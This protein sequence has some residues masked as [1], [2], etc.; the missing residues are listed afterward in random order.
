MSTRRRPSRPPRRASARPAAAA[1]ASPT[2]IAS[3]RS[4]PAFTCSTTALRFWNEAWTWPPRRSVITG[5]AALVGTCRPWRPRLA[6]RRA[7]RSD[8]HD[9]PLPD[10]A[11][12]I[13]SGF[14]LSAA[15]TSASALER[16]SSG[17]HQHVGRLHGHRDQVE[18]LER[19][20][21]HVLDQVRCDHQRPERGDE[22]RVTVGSGALDDGCA[23]RAGRARLVLDDERLPELLLQL[24]R[25]RTGDR[26]RGAARGGTARRS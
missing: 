25:D 15:I 13:V 1:S 16:R 17:N 3:A 5:P 7:P 24:R 14:A 22:Q 26:I 21:L 11:N 18:V 6:A 23:D 9:E 12:E 8:G 4:L 19:V 20:V 10:E 2:V